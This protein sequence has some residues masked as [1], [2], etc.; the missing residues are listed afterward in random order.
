MFYDFSKHIRKVD[1]KDYILIYTYPER[2]TAEEQEIIIRFAKNNN[3]KLLS[4]GCCYPWSETVI[5][6][7][8]FQ[9]LSYFD[10]A[11]YVIT[12]T[13]H[14]TVF[15]VKYNKNFCAFIRNSNQ[16][17]L[18]FLLQQFDQQNR[19][20]DRAS[21]LCEILMNEPDYS[22]TNEIIKSERLRSID[23]LSDFT[24]SINN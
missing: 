9:V 24:C 8:P 21:D 17:K 23:F 14:G 1:A 20:A 15:A 22:R 10:S 18:Q 19:K 13:F 3:K 16:F 4:I 6:D 2:I 11:D 5:P 12:D 7:S